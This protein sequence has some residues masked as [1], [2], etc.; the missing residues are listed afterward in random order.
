MSS[1][2]ISIKKKQTTDS[3]VKSKIPYDN[4]K[5]ILNDGYTIDSV[6]DTINLIVD[7]IKLLVENEILIISSSNVPGISITYTKDTDESDARQ[8]LEYLIA[9]NK[10]T[11]DNRYNI[12]YPVVGSVI[13]CNRIISPPYNNMQPYNPAMGLGYSGYQYGCC[14]IYSQQPQQN[15]NYVDI[16]E[17]TSDDW[18]DVYSEEYLY[19]KL[20]YGKH[21]DNISTVIYSFTRTLLLL[22]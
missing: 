20:H 9:V 21:G 3:T 7:D 5:Y 13:Q 6:N 4:S 15:P 8:S 16:S 14:N 19:K 2:T 10:A 18:I 12:Q 17:D 11:T 22:R 1:I